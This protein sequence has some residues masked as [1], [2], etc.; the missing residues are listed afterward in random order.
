M[1]LGT[2]PPACSCKGAHRVGTEVMQAASLVCV[3]SW[4]QQLLFPE[5]A[6]IGV[7]QLSPN[8]SPGCFVHRPPITG[9]SEPLYPS[10]H[11]HWVITLSP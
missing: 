3:G 8:R 5:P 10:Q 1:E 2:S 9:G 4:R 6:A 7:E 11:L